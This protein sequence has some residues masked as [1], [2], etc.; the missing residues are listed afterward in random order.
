MGHMQRCCH[1]L[2][3]TSSALLCAPPGSPR[4]SADA[5]LHASYT[6]T[7]A[8][9]AAFT[10]LARSSHDKSTAQCGNV[11]VSTSQ[12]LLQCSSLCIWAILSMVH[13]WSARPTLVPDAGSSIILM[14]NGDQCIAAV[15]WCFRS[16]PN[17]SIT[18]RPYTGRPGEDVDDLLRLRVE[19]GDDAVMASEFGACVLV[20]ASVNPYELVDRAIAAAA[21]LSGGSLPPPCCLVDM[22][23]PVVPR[24]YSMS[25]KQQASIHVPKM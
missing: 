2:T 9:R 21:R 15:T 8:G 1:S 20:A 24:G 16:Q 10:Q 13:L 18:L 3:A 17:A 12:N 25:T 7:A 22:L 5:S 23:Y 14:P 6:C 4:R 19:S 11:R